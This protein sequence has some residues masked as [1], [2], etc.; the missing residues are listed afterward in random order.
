MSRRVGDTRNWTADE[1]TQQLKVSEEYVGEYFE[2]MSAQSQA[3]GPRILGMKYWG[4]GRYSEAFS[5]YLIATGRQ[6]LAADEALLPYAAA[7]GGRKAWLTEQLAEASLARQGYFKACLAYAEGDY[8]KVVSISPAELWAKDGQDAVSN[9]LVGLNMIRARAYLR[10]DDQ[11]EARLALHESLREEDLTVAEE[12]RMQTSVLGIELW[13]FAAELE[14]ECGN[15]RQAT[16]FVE[17]AM[18]TLFTQCH[19]DM[20]WRPLIRQV[21]I[22]KAQ[23]EKELQKAPV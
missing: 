20:S 18:L 3:S 21:E 16:T 10:L 14:A 19:G 6:P 11:Y 13:R 17:A 9:W 2:K 15:L 7:L 8:A 1:A 4:E 12:V 22:L 23:I 5:A